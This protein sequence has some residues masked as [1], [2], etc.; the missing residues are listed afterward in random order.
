FSDQ[1]KLA[2]L[3]RDNA[4]YLLS[5]ANAPRGKILR[6]PLE[7]PELKNAAEIVSAGEAVI[8]QIVPG[9]EALYVGDLLGGPSQI[10]RFDLN[11]KNEVIIS[12][13]KIS[14]VQEM[15]AL[16]DGSLLFRDVSYTEPAAWFHCL[17]GKTQPTKTALW[18]TSPVSF[19][20]IEVMR[21]FATSKDG[22]KIPLNIIFRKGIKRDGQNPTLLYGYGGYGVS[23]SPNFD[24]TRRLWFD[25]GGVYVV[26]NIRGGGEFGEDW[27]KAGNLTKKQNVF[28]HFAAAAEYLI[29]QQYTCPEKLGI[30]GGSNGGLLM[31]A[32]ITQH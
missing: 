22:T 2:R 28:E 30:M 9:R 23:M 19:A 27:H 31:G 1:I 10:R 11:G 16:E 25:H 18:N 8:E 4:L 29:K 15:L 24:F 6:L 13:P 20:D 5:R 12:I 17:T 32:L 14:A 7:A 26:A 21:E 3:G